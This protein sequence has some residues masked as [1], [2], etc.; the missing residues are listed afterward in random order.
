M[1]AMV[2]WGREDKLIPPSTAE[3]WLALLPTARCSL[4]PEAGH[5]PAREQPAASAAAILDFV[6]SAA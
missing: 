4:V 1:P 3:Q 5:F 2:M 6:R